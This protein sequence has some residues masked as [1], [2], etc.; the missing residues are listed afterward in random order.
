MNGI[1]WFTTAQFFNGDRG[2]LFVELLT[3]LMA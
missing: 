3:V 2:Q 1:I